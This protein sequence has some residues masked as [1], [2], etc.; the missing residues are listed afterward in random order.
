MFWEVCFGRLWAA[1]MH[2]KWSPQ[3]SL[4]HL[5]LLSDRRRGQGHGRRGCCMAPL[6]SMWRLDEQT[7]ELSQKC[8]SLVACLNF[9]CFEKLFWEGSS[10]RERE[11]ER[12]CISAM[13]QLTYGALA[14]LSHNAFASQCSLRRQDRV[15]WL[16]M[17]AKVKAQ[18]N[19]STTETNVGETRTWPKAN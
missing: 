16:K 6:F 1:L 19:L 8:N 9:T 4:V 2:M 14:H 5:L 12:R 3:D 18:A 17:A 7:T 11:R 15:A 10:W 13:M